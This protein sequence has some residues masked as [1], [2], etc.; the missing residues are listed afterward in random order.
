MAAHALVVMNAHTSIQIYQAMTSHPN[1]L[2]QIPA[3]HHRTGDEAEVEEKER[4][5][6]EKVRAAAA[7]IQPAAVVA[8]P[9]AIDHR[10]REAAVPDR[11]PV[12]D[13]EENHLQANQMPEPVLST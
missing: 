7:A 4:R 2:D 10:V 13:V 9:G 11:I 1:P 5:V 12:E 8:T 3:I 6:E